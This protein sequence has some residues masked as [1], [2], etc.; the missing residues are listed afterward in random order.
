ML[1]IQ[2]YMEGIRLSNISTDKITWPAFES[3]G[4]GA[5]MLRLDKIH[6]LISGNK[7]FKLRYYLQEA[8]QQNKERIVTSGGAWSNH[9]IATAAACKLRSISC[10]GIIRGER[11]AVLS[12]TLQQAAELGMEFI[13]ISRGDYAAQKIPEHLQNETNYT[14]PQGGYGVAGARGASE[15]LNYCDREKYTH[16][17]CAV[18]TGTMLAGLA[19][20]ALPLQQVIGISVLKNNSQP[21]KDVKN[22]IKKENNNFRILYDYHS[23]GYAKYNVQLIYFMNEFFRQTGIPT[24]F[25]YTGKL[26]FAVTDLVQKDFFPPRSRLLLIHSGGLTGNASLKKGLLIF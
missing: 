12:N 19:D 24:D 1:L 14:I 15:M 26:S 9:I 22:L 16:I 10:T 13:F 17:C 3:N 4:I 5:D 8:K 21:E 6:P 11:P 18:G 20:A 7:W 2:F 25:V 23:G